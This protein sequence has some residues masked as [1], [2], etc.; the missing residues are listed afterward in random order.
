MD[1]KCK[2][3]LELRL[4]GELADELN[5]ARECVSASWLVSSRARL[6]TRWFNRSFCFIPSLPLHLSCLLR[7][8]ISVWSTVLSLI[9]WPEFEFTE[10]CTE[11]RSVTE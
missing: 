1:Y 7:Y 8:I 9:Q 10:Q 11:S 6:L 2:R 3:Q 4:I 5:R